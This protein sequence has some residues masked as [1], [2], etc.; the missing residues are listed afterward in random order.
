[1]ARWRTDK[2]AEQADTIETV[3]ELLNSVRGER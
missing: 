1:M 3:R 2:K